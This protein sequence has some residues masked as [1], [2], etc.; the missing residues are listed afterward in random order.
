M[1]FA[2]YSVNRIRVSFSLIILLVFIGSNSCKKAE[3]IYTIPDE[4]RAPTTPIRGPAQVLQI[5]SLTNWYP[6]TP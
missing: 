5:S 2:N 1:V 3:S 6:Q 4:F